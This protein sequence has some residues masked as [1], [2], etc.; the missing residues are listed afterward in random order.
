MSEEKPIKSELSYAARLS[1]MIQGVAMEKPEAGVLEVYG[2][3]ILRLRPRD[4]CD[5]QFVEGVDDE[6]RLVEPAY[7]VCVHCG[8][9]RD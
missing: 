6:G 4:E 1:L 8:E 3:S 5:H 2:E 7:D 9:R